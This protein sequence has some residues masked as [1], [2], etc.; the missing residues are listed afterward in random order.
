[1][2]NFIDTENIANKNRKIPLI[3]CFNE[4]LL[5]VIKVFRIRNYK[6]INIVFRAKLV[7]TILP[8]SDFF[9]TQFSHLCRIT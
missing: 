8:K 6:N 4:T 1:M 3:A 9:G 7:T 5:N 2:K